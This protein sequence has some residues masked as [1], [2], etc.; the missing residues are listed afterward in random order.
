MN[1]CVLM[2]TSVSVLSSLYN[3]YSN[4]STSTAAGVFLSVGSAVHLFT[5]RLGANYATT[6]RS[7]FPRGCWLLWE[8]GRE[9]ILWRWVIN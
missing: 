2:V 4:F 6:S 5:S 8:P 7:S 3:R 9:E 1:P